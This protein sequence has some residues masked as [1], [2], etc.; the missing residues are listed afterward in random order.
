V[1]EEAILDLVDLQAVTDPF[2]KK[3]RGKSEFNESLISLNVKPLFKK[4]RIRMIMEEMG[5]LT[6]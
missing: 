5:D 4:Q 6:K 3:K 2:R 1:R